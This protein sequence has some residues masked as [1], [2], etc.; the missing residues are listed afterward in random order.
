[1]NPVYRLLNR[2]FKMEER[3]TTLKT[4]FFSGLTAYFTVVYIF[5]L[6]PST[7][8][9]AFPEAFN[10]R[11]QMI[12]NAILSNGVTANQMLV[13]LTA[14]C[15]IAAAIGT[16][17]M[18]L[19]SNM[20]F[21]Q[22][23]SLAI[24]TYVGYSICSR[25]GYTYAEALAAVFT[26][27]VVFLV[28]IVFGIDRKIEKAIPVNI[29]YAVTAGIGL[30]ITFMGMQK[31]HLIV[32]D[33]AHLVKLV[34]LSDWGSYETRSAVLCLIGVVF[35][36]VLLIEHIHGAILIG[37]LAC[38]AAAIPLGLVH[39]V[40][41]Q[42]MAHLDLSPVIFEMD[43]AGLF[44]PHHDWGIPGMVISIVVI[45]VTLCIMD[46]F[47]TMG[48]I[49]AADFI[50][51]HNH[52]GSAS[53]KMTEILQADSISTVIG[54]C[55]GMTNVSTYVESTSVALE[56][57]RTGLS[58]IFA[59]I[60]FLLTVFISPYASMIP[61]AATATTLIVSGVLMINVIHYISFKDVADALPAFLTMGLMPLT[62]NIIAGLAFG[63]I[64]YTCIRLFSKKKRHELNIGCILLT[65]AFLVELGFVLI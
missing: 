51:N 12:G 36:A 47:E 62:Y 38:I 27:G 55:F 45:I 54:S 21:V 64:S 25:L 3:G 32:P 41:G 65:L 31:A 10:E 43:F 50:I 59:A 17:V 5:F 26:G 20:P 15:C 14:A 9:E 13:S 29:K 7:L 53:K 30:F 1:M 19:R 4:E 57:G 40:Q 34:N 8:M 6:V 33:S 56:G 37:K 49:M 58:G 35:I 2:R 48:T 23:P 44:S 28:L 24:S 16:L 52:M 42:E 11:G 22:G 18:A 63:M 61:S 39:F 60:F 46:I